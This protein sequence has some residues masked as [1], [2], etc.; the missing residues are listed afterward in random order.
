MA[1]AVWGALIGQ[2]AAVDRLSAA[3]TDAERLTRG[4]SGPAMTH[5]WLITGPPGSGRSTAAA[6]FA[7]A[8]VCPEHGCGQCRAC[9]TAKDGGHPDVVIHRTDE[10]TLKVADVH[11][12]ID[13]AALAPVESPWRVVVIEDADRMTDE[14][15]AAMLKEFEEPSQH[16]VWVLCAPTVEDVLPTLVSRARH[17]ALTTPT[18]TTIAAML[19]ERFGVD[20]AMAAFAARASQGHIGRAKGL[21]TDEASRTRRHEVLRI[22]T[23]LR[24]LPSC[25]IAAGNLHGAAEEDANAISGPREERE[26]E[27]LQQMYG[28]GGDVRIK[29]QLKR[30]FDADVKELEKRQK[31]RRR[32]ALLDQIDRALVDLMGLYRDVLVVQFDAPT[33]LINEEMRPQ[34]EALAANTTAADTARRLDAI[35]HCR[36][37]ITGDANAQPLIALESLMVELKDPWIRLGQAG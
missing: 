8:L 6:M 25:F 26:A 31:S 19:V 9:R 24:D 13:E 1:T 23:Q 3:V 15:A 34:V 18:A 4:E 22:P 16:T 12:L 11:T 2:D 14:A 30:S 28:A 29:G 21:A 17:V 37:L 27:Q 20:E 36:F 7:T 5:A 33:P 35:E 32:R 10:A